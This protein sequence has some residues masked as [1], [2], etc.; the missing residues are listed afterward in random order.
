MRFEKINN[1]F[2]N[3]LNAWNDAMWYGLTGGYFCQIFSGKSLK[4]WKG[5]DFPAVKNRNFCSG[6]TDINNKFH[7]EE[8]DEIVKVKVTKYKHEFQCAE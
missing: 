2:V 7:N 4:S 1:G 5:Y 6:I 3:V 8:I